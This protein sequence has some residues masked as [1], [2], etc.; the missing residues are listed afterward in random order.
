MSVDATVGVRL[1]HTG[2]EAVKARLQE[3]NAELKRNNLTIDQHIKKTREQSSLTNVLINAERNKTRAYLAQHPALNQSIRSMHALASAARTVLTVTT[4]FN[5]ARLAF[6]GVNSE[7]ADASV[8]L[9]E[10]KRELELAMA[11]GDPEKIRE[12]ADAVG[13]LDQKVKEL[14]D[15]AT[16]DTITNFLNLGATLA[17]IG[18]GTGKIISRIAT[19]GKLS[20]IFTAIKGFGSVATSLAGP[21]AGVGLGIFAGESI[22]ENFLGGK[23]ILGQTKEDWDNFF[24]RDGPLAV[25]TFVQTVG[26]LINVSLANALSQLPILWHGLLTKLKD[27]LF[28]FID[29]FTAGL[30]WLING[31]VKVVNGMISAYNRVAKVV[32]GLPHVDPLDYIVLQKFSEEQGGGGK[33]RGRGAGDGL[34]VFSLDNFIAGKTGGGGAQTIVNVYVTGSVV[35]ENDLVQVILKRLGQEQNRRGTMNF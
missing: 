9:R 32:P 16:Q 14:K 31:F 4:A 5:V 17:L 19:A 24:L 6:G 28:K 1:R 8:K 33:S 15:S 13:V 30:Q 34:N 10:A 7:L 12:A 22:K 27:N 35:S 20:T 25:H 21:L 23:T 2:F 26:S 29:K 11:S 18:D 3:V